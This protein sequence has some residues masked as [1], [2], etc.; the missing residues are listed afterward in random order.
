MAFTPPATAAAASLPT[1]P[2]GTPRF[3]PQRLGMHAVQRLLH[4]RLGP[5]RADVAAGA[6]QPQRPVQAGQTLS[7][8]WRSGNVLYEGAPRWAL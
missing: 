7:Q 2:A 3:S 1:R 6:R 5:E 8:L 4:S